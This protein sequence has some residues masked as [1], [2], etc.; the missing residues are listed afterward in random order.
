MSKNASVFWVL[1]DAYRLLHSSATYSLLEIQ[2]S[3]QQGPPPHTHHREEESFFVL[4]G[5]LAVEL[6]DQH[7][8]LKAGEFLHL[9]VGVRHSYKAV[10]PRG[11][12]HLTQLVP[13]GLEQFFRAIGHEDN[14]AHDRNQDIRKL[15]ELAPR[16][17]LEVFAQ[18]G[19]RE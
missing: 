8:S 7:I 17:G 3:E 9:P 15:L 13:G 18:N 19:P 1:G 10:S 11:A 4:D 14:A 5:E 16:Y 12:R 6:G 2:T